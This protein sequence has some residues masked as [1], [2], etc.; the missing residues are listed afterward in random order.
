MTGRAGKKRTRVEC[1]HS[2]EFPLIEMTRLI[3]GDEQ[4][5]RWIEQL[6]ARVIS[7]DLLEILVKWGFKSDTGPEFEEVRITYCGAFTVWWKVRS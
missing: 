1:L 4:D 6:S 5:G 2:H 3:V 7:R